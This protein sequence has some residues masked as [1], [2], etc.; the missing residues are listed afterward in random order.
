MSWATS[1]TTHEQGHMLGLWHAHSY[2][3]PWRGGPYVA[4]ANFCDGDEYGD[5]Y[6]TMGKGGAVH[7]NGAEKHTL[8]WLGTRETDLTNGGSATLAP[9]EQQAAAP[10]VARVA[11]SSFR[12]YYG[13]YRQY[14]AEYRQLLGADS[15]LGFNGASTHGTD[16]VLIHAVDPY[17]GYGDAGTL[18][19]DMNPD[20]NFY[21]ATL[22]S[23]QSWTTPEGWTF[24]VG[25][26]SS[27]GAAL[28]VTAPA[29]VAGAPGTPTATAGDGSATVSW[30]VPSSTAAARSPATRS[31]PPRAAPRRPSAPPPALR[32]WP[33]SPTAPATPSR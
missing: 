12:Q 15:N 10:Q 5:P 21:D 13:E 31:P 26:L 19:L 17:N 16:G 2:I 1:L 4:M 30:T 23:G 32:P 11:V 3:C 8:G 14:Y 28:T 29:R 9:L 20:A 25:A 24:T 33:G 7:Y 22:K 6:D 18:L 27:S